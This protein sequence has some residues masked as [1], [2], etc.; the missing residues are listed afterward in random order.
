MRLHGLLSNS[1]PLPIYP[2]CSLT[3]PARQNMT[4]DNQIR[5]GDVSLLVTPGLPAPQPAS[6]YHMG[7]DILI[8]IL[9]K[10]RDFATLWSIRR[11]CLEFFR[12][13]MGDV[14]SNELF[15]HTLQRSLIPIEFLPTLGRGIRLHHDSRPTMVLMVHNYNMSLWSLFRMMYYNML[16]NMSLYDEDVVFFTEDNAQ[17]LRQHPF[18]FPILSL[19]SM[20]PMLG[21]TLDHFMA[22]LLE[23]KQNETNVGLQRKKE[24][25]VR[26]IIKADSWNAFP[27]VPGVFS[28]QWSHNIA[29]IVNAY[30]SRLDEWLDEPN[31]Q[32]L[33]TRMISHQDGRR[34][35]RTHPN[36][37][38]SA[39][40][41]HKTVYVELPLEFRA[42]IE[43]EYVFPLFEFSVQNRDGCISSLGQFPLESSKCLLRTGY[44]QRPECGLD[45]AIRNFVESMVPDTDEET[46]KVAIKNKTIPGLLNLYLPRQWTS[47][48]CYKKRS[49]LY[50]I[51]IATYS[52]SMFRGSELL[53]M[54]KKL[55]DIKDESDIWTEFINSKRG[56]YAPD[57]ALTFIDDSRPGHRD[58]RMKKRS[59]GTFDDSRM[60]S[61]SQLKERA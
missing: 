17:Q 38:P 46:L 48:L 26:Y 15:F 58:K 44:L 50:K 41:Q 49:M 56:A 32:I 37:S 13:V 43:G 9:Q 8:I 20:I 7:S 57:M 39:V 47:S 31:N 42:I 18:T 33:A 27:N 51:L 22:S 23:R 4:Y 30:A 35:I 11:V 60:S 12:L 10:L 45:T 53:F 54:L 3:S 16:M 36:T 21:V 34:V 5:S 25:L 40:Q 19:Q 55:Y 59:S 29:V 52:S 61:S 2:A 28:G 1:T 6:L 24:L 14:K